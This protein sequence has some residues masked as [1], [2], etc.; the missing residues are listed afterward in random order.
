M[1][2]GDNSTLVEAWSDVGQNT[3]GCRTRR[4]RDKQFTRYRHQWRYDQ[5]RR[6]PRGLDSD[7]RLGAVRRRPRVHQ[8][9][10]DGRGGRTHAACRGSYQ[11]SYPVRGSTSRHS[12]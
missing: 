9:G 4:D 11:G 10:F 7:V 5:G 1:Q 3:P 8:T 2:A 12:W 6:R